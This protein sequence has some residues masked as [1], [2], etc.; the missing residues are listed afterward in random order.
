MFGKDRAMGGR[1]KSFTDVG[2]NDLVR[3][4]AFT[5]DAASDTNFQPMYSQGLSMSL[6]E[7]MGTRTALVSE[8]RYISSGSK[9]KREG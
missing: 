8:G 9:R 3:Y 2:S 7:L 6:D 4:E 1:P 5:A